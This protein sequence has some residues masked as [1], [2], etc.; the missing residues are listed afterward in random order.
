MRSKLIGI[1]FKINIYVIQIKN[2][3][4]MPDQYYSWLLTYVI[5]PKSFK[6]CKY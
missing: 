5:S 6:V 2:L 4:L 1:K 3:T